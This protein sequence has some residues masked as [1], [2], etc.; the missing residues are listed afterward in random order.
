MTACSAT[1]GGL[2]LLQAAAFLGNI[3]ED[4]RWFKLVAPLAP[5]RLT[6]AAADLQ[7]LGRTSCSR[8]KV[9]LLNQD[10]IQNLLPF[11]FV[12]YAVSSLY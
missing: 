4:A 3:L 7:Q 5:S 12:R 9:G 2:P 8:H 11:L 10:G 6:L 1:S